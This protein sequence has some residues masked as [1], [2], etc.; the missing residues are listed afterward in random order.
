[1]YTPNF[2]SYKVKQQCNMTIKGRVIMVF[3]Q[4]KTLTLLG[5][6]LVP[7]NVKLFSMFF[8]TMHC[9][10]DETDFGFL[11]MFYLISDHIFSYNTT[12]VIHEG[13]TIKLP[14]THKICHLI[15][16]NQ[17]CVHQSP[18]LVWQKTIL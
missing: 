16:F 11:K 12:F 6:G 8:I 5:L 9:I 7:L 14:P 17:L 10:C 13:H 15:F 1:M 18:L 4:K 3:C 2:G